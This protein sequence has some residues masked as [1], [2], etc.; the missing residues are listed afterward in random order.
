VLALGDRLSEAAS[1]R[2]LELALRDEVAFWEWLEASG[3][4]VE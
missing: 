1:R 3:G 4:E 2:R